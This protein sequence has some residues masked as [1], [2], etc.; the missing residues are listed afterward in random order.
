MILNDVWILFNYLTRSTL[1]TNVD[2]K[3]AAIN[4]GYKFLAQRMIQKGKPIPQLVSTPTTLTIAATDNKSTLPTD[5]LNIADVYVKAGTDYQQL[6]EDT[7]LEYNMFREQVGDDFLDSASTGIPAYCSINEPYIY[8][9]TYS[10]AAD[11]TWAKI[12]YNKVPATLVAYDRLTFA[13]NTGTF[14]VGELVTGGTTESTGY[15]YAKGSTYVDIYTSTRDGEFA[16]GEVITGDGGAT[17]TLTVE[18]TEK[19]QTL[20]ISDKYKMLLANAA[21]LTWLYM[22]DEIEL[23]AKNT[24]MDA[25]IENMQ[26][27]NKARTSFTFGLA[28]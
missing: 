28:K 7:I 2:K 1:T 16:S 23:E 13:T 15:I 24:T 14:V 22:N 3:M 19:P 20:E 11:T 26:T 18:M 6:G 27:I 9:D 21:A 5:F 25:L 4:E 10:S 8:W 17:A 12:I